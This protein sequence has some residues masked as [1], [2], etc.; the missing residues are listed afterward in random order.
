MD[1]DQFIDLIRASLQDIPEPFASHLEQVDI[2][3][4][5]RPS[6]ED[7]EDAG[8]RPGESMYGF[9][10]GIPLTERNSGYTLVA[11]DIINI[12]QEPLEEDFPHEEDLVDEIRIT[13]L[14]ELAHFFGI[15]D[16]RLEE[17]GLD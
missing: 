5:R 4:K 3:V 1:R 7:L 6:R 12:Y 16:N 10:R 14:H 8:L 17:L 15:D 2:V 11:P 9:Y 13:V